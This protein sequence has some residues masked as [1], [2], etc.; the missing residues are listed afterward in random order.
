MK[1]YLESNQGPKQP[2]SKRKQSFKAKV[3]EMYYD[4]SH[5]N[6]YYFYQQCKDYFE[7]TRAIKANRTSFAAFFL[8]GSISVRWMQYKRRHWVRN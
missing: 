7:T 5:M 4:K 8:C 3:P 1:A 6:C 2:L